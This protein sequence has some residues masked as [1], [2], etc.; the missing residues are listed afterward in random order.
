MD[1]PQIPSLEGGSLRALTPN[2][3]SPRALRIV[4]PGG[5]GQVGQ[6]LARYFQERGHHV[7]VLTRGPYTAPWQTVHWD[8][9]NPGLW[10]ETLDGADVCINLT[11]RSVNCRLN[12]ANR[13]AMYDSRI[14]STRLLNRVIAGLANPLRVWLNAS[15]ATIYRHAL[16]RPMDEATGE[17]GGNEL[18]SRNRHAPETWNFSVH[19]AKDWEAALFDT[20]TP[21]T[22]KVA[23]RSAITFSPTQGNAF[24]V[25]SNLVRT[26]LGGKQGNGRQYVSWIHEEDFARA[27]E[28]LIDHDE[29]AGPINIAAPNPLPNREFMSAL[30]D[31]WDIPNGLPAP[32]FAIEIGAFFLRTES[33]LV[34][35]SR[36]VVPGRLLDAGFKF[37]FPDWP[38]AAGDLVQQWRRRND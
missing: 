26:G 9:V 12:A 29:M 32:A 7:T 28:F 27:V 24:Q 15:T 8:A 1:E 25:F 19:V 6:M 16:D 34:L 23:L 18:V 13:R 35:K 21:R 22:R 3:V 11:G 5:S 31:A 37:D 38:A 20:E 36:R 30:R 10:T 17:L 4:L 14:G 33:E 2:S